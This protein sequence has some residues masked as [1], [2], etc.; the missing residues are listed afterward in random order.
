MEFLKDFY[1]L[2]EKWADDFSTAVKESNA[3]KQFEI[4]QNYKELYNDYKKN[5]GFKKC[6]EFDQLV[7]NKFFTKAQL[8]AYDSLVEEK[9][10]EVE[11]GTLSYK[12]FFNIL[13]YWSEN[14]A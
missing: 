14:Y 4:E 9:I 13:N 2:Q 12:D 5:N 7:N 10:V 8:E 3:S 6:I 1:K 11:K